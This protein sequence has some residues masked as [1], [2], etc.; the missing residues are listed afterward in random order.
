MAEPFYY[1][2]LDIYSS[3][4]DIHSTPL[5]PKD[6]SRWIPMRYIINFFKLGA[7]I[8]MFLGMI[9]FDNFSKASWVYLALHGSYG[10]IWVLKDIIF[11]DAFMMLKVGAESIVLSLILIMYYTPGIM[12]LT[13]S[14]EQTP[15]DER[16]F[17]CFVMFVIGTV[18]MFGTDATKYVTLKLKKGLIDN[19]LVEKNRNT[20]F[21]GEIMLYSSFSLITGEIVSY[22]P[23]LIVWTFLFVSRIWQK[24][25]SL[26]K[27]DG[28]N[29]YKEKSY[30]ILFKIFDSDIMNFVLYASMIGITY[31]T[32]SN[33][34]I[35]LTVRKFI[36]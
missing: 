13:R 4:A 12:V 15:S 24:E 17:V 11:P 18:I 30:L 3:L 23:Y 2:Y 26:M 33:G 7:F 35:E 36:K 19:Y 10:L 14:C 9:Y 20:N 32:Y 6:R 27:K 28:Y 22:I 1:K 29:R 25:R 16:V 21:L 8:F 5:F 34:G 31:F